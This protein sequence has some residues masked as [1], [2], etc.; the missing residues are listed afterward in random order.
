MTEKYLS[1]PQAAKALGIKTHALGRA[2]NAEIVP[3]H[4]FFNNRKRVLLSEI[5]AAAKE[6]QNA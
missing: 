3:S 5:I 6:A 4:K 2:V 1:I